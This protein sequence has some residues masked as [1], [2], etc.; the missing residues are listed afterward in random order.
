MTFCVYSDESYRESSIYD[1]SS[2]YKKLNLDMISK[3]GFKQAYYITYVNAKKK[4]FEKLKEKRY[5]N[6]K[7]E[8]ILL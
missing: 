5:Q 6:M 4:I 8:G 3:F 2:I 1:Y 7:R